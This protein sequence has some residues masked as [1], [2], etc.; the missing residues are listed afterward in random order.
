L[1]YPRDRRGCHWTHRRRGGDTAALG[2]VRF[3]DR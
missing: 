2:P 1:I 3:E